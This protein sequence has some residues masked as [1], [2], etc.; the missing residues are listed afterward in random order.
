[1][2]FALAIATGIYIC[3]YISKFDNNVIHVKYTKDEFRYDLI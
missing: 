1:M 2:I 3:I